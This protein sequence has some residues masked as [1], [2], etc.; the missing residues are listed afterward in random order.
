MH[1]AVY[2]CMH[3][4]VSWGCLSISLVHVA[5]FLCLCLCLGVSLSPSL[6]LKAV[7]CVCS[8]LVNT[9]HV[10]EAVVVGDIKPTDDNMAISLPPELLLKVPRVTWFPTLW[11]WGPG[12]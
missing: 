12:S 3:D 4:A 10:M 7:R 6:P 2:V 5:L 11:A 9:V 1:D 8:A